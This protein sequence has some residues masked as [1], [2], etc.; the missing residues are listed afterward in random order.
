MAPTIN[1]AG[2]DRRLA[3]VKS[4][5]NSHNLQA[6]SIDTVAYDDS[7]P[8]PYNNFLFHVQLSPPA[9]PS[10]FPGTQPG[11]ETAPAD[12]LA[13]FI[14]KLCNPDSGLN[15]TNRVENNVATH[16]L[17]RQAMRE[18]QLPSLV[19]AIYAWGRHN[20][21]I[22]SFA[23]T[24]SEFKP[25]V[26]LDS[27]FPSLSP[28]H[29]AR[30]LHD[31][32]AVL[33]ALQTVRL[34]ATVTEFGGLTFN[35]SGQIISGEATLQKGEPEAT[36]IA[37]KQSS[38]LGALSR[39]EKSPVIQGWRRNDLNQRIQSFLEEGGLEKLFDRVD[40]HQKNLIHGDF[41]LNNMMFDTQ[42]G[43]LTAIIDFD[44][45]C[46][47]NPAEEFLS[48]LYDV[49]GNISDERDKF[50]ESIISGS[51]DVLSSAVQDE[52]T[53]KEWDLA[54]AWNS[55]MKSTGCTRPSEISG[56]RQILGVQKLQSLLCPF[57]LSNP[58]R[59]ERMSDETKAEALAKAEAALT[60]WLQKHGF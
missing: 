19:P 42:K 35:K 30:L 1:A 3:V 10:S 41:T 46:I 50:H 24:I 28:V 58:H 16:L 47:S 60:E 4:I 56:I 18:A 26:D 53:R 57:Q 5:I 23:W 48:G 38:L 25:G 22:G 15:D 44:W 36:Y 45:S 6:S 34:P 13:S 29:Q 52:E 14:I 17:V 2:F 20:D 31:I 27:V 7:C 37:C 49:G 51:F 40:I 11:T 43:E 55:A 8:H 54:K 21:G 9:S 59:L 33:K 12:G 32:A 39:A